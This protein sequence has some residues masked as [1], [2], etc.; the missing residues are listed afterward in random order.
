[1]L[2][3]KPAGVLVQ[4]VLA[5]FASRGVHGSTAIAKLA[6]LGQPQVHRNLYGRPKRVSKTLC[7]LCKYAEIATHARSFDP[8]ECETLIVAL[9]QVWNGT[10]GHARKLAKLLFAHHQ[11]RV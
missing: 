6:R 8:R 9:S 10:E 2:P 1:M 11:A 7:A 3:L 4:E 5:H